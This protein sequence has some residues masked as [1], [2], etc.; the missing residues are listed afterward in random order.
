MFQCCW[1]GWTCYASSAVLARHAQIIVTKYKDASR[2]RACF[3]QLVFYQTTRQSS[4]L[5]KWFKL[6]ILIQIGA[7]DLGSDRPIP[8]KDIHVNKTIPSDFARMKKETRPLDVGGGLHSQ[9][10]SSREALV[11]ELRPADSWEVL[12]LRSAIMPSGFT[13]DSA[14]NETNEKRLLQSKDGFKVR[15]ALGLD[16]VGDIIRSVVTFTGYSTGDNSLSGEPT[17]LNGHTIVG[18]PRNIFFIENISNRPPIVKKMK[19]TT[20]IDYKE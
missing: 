14:N 13:L 2:V 8:P 18:T 12:A 3:K 6:I 11:W 9:R 16:N 20:T 17:A 1:E 5:N 10:Y 7:T 4:Y 15:H 19:K